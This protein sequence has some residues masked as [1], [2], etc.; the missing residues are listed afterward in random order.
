M[1]LN[2]AKASQDPDIP[3]KLIKQNIDIFTDLLHSAFN[4]CLENS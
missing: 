4:N 2:S 3:T 1:N